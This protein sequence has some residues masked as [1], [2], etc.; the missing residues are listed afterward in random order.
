MSSGAFGTGPGAIAPAL[1]QRESQHRSF[2]RTRL[3]KSSIAQF[4][5]V[6]WPHRWVN[7]WTGRLSAF[8]VL[9][10][11]RDSAILM[12][13]VHMFTRRP[14]QPAAIARD[15]CDVSHLDPVKLLELRSAL[16]DHDNAGALAE[17]FKVLGD[18]TRVRIL[19]ALARTE[20]CVCDLAQLLGMTESAISHQLRLLRA[21][22]VVRPRRAGR[23]VFYALDDRHIIRLFRQ[24][25]RHPQEPAARSRLP[26]RAVEVS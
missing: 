2:R 21:R 16:I 17:I 8:R 23:R 5:S 12:A 3:R 10:G 7:P 19:D 1:A 11:A 20:L 4:F 15:R 6:I 26:G 18:V 25:L 22:R 24:G 9:A 13:V 14:A